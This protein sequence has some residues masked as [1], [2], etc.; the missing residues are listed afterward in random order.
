MIPIFIV[1]DLIRPEIEPVF[2]VSGADAIS[3]RP[4]IGV[5]A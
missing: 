4:L 5:K 3:T 2:I 1:F